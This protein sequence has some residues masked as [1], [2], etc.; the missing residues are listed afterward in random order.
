MSFEE[1]L[2]LG[3]AEVI[4]ISEARQLIRGNQS[5]FVP[6]SSIRNIE[7]RLF[8]LVPETIDV[9]QYLVASPKP[10]RAVY[11]AVPA[12]WSQHASPEHH[13]AE[14]LPDEDAAVELQDMPN[15]L[16]DIDRQ[17]PSSVSVYFLNYI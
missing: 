2:Q 16:S 9:P 17:M 8:G 12:V 14:Y 15:Y 7:E 11:E 13:D 5:T 4:R 3:V 6:V 1:G 10:V